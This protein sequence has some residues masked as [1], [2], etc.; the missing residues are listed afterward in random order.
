MLGDAPKYKTQE[1]V[2]VFGQ[3]EGLILEVKPGMI[4]TTYVV[5][6]AGKIE[7]CQEFNL[8]P[9]TGQK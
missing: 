7:E 3:F 4:G 6:Y 1:T 2:L 5:Q 8:K 9:W